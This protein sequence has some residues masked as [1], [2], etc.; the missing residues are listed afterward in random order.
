MR[1]VVALLKPVELEPVRQALAAVHVTRLTVG[2]A[3][4]HL[5]PMA[6]RTGPDAAAAAPISR[7]VIMEIAVN[8]D[9]LDRT[10]RTIAAAL[11]LAATEGDGPADERVFV[12]PMEDAVQLYRDVRGPE[13]I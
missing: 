6:N 13:A 5:L 12:L 4:Q 9:F 1:L 7:H 10:V 8:D 2:D 11:R 3:Q